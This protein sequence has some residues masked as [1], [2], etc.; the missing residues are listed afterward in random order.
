MSDEICG[1]CGF[2]IEGITH[3]ACI[4]HMSERLP[5]YEGDELTKEKVNLAF[6]V[7]GRLAGMLPGVDELRVSQKPFSDGYVE[8]NKRVSSWEQAEKNPVVM[9]EHREQAASIA[10]A[11][12]RLGAEVGEGLIDVT[13]RVGRERREIVFR[14][15]QAERRLAAQFKRNAFLSDALSEYVIQLGQVKEQIKLMGT[16]AGDE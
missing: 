6:A 12:T 9:D 7:V 5:L 15:D 2:S 1:A 4:K 11:M 16:K 14:A 3:D 8:I 10:L 13:K